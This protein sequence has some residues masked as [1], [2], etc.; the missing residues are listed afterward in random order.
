MVKCLIFCAGEFSGMLDMPAPGDL[1]IAADGGYRHAQCAQICPD[2]V[3]GDFDSLGYIPEGAM[4]HPVR[5]DDTDAMLAVKYGLQQGYR[6]FVLYGA[7]EGTRLDHTLA[8]YQ[9]LQYLATAGAV[10]YLVGKDTLATVIREE[11]VVFPQGKEGTLSLF[12]M[13]AD[14]RGVCLRG[15][16]YSMEDG[17]LQSDF[18]LGVSN[19]FTKEQAVITVASGSLLCLWDRAVGLPDR[20]KRKQEE[21]SYGKRNELG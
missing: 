11:T 16:G 6:E 21:C 18:P 12:C 5:K 10:G 3:L 14:A 17:T 4:V 1:C 20:E 19:Y 7:M 8:A 15:L 2:V 13:G 9:T